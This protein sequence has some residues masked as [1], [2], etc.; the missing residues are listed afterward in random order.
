MEIASARG[1]FRPN[2][3]YTERLF[4][5][6][7]KPFGLFTTKTNRLESRRRAKPGLTPHFGRQFLTRETMRMSWGVSASHISVTVSVFL[8][9]SSSAR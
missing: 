9:R 1:I 6:E 5:F 2:T 3:V 4:E 8:S 7:I